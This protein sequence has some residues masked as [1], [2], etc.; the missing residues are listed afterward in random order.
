M[1]V[2]VFTASEENYKLCVERGDC[3]S[4]RINQGRHI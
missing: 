1:A 4:A 2:Y 3:C